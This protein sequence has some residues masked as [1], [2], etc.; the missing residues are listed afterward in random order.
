[1]VVNIAV[2]ALLWVARLVTVLGV[3]LD[4]I[5]AL[6]W[7]LSGTSNWSALLSVGVI[8]AG[9]ALSLSPKKIL[10]KNGYSFALLGLA[11]TSI[12]VATLILPNR[13]AWFDLPANQLYLVATFSAWCAIVW[14]LREV[15]GQ[16]R[17]TKGGT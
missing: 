11:L 15:S 2:S 9:C 16:P 12:G 5:I 10:L 3:L 6:V 1:M 13:V 8:L 7:F 14:L 4:E 17:T